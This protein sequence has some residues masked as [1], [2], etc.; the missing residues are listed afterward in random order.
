M[1]D[2][3]EQI[4]VVV[5][6]GK[7]SK[8]A[9][10]PPELKDQD[11]AD[12]IAADALKNGVQPI[13]LLEGCMMGMERIGKEFGEG[14]AFVTNLIVSAE[15]MK[16]VM[17]HIKPFLESGEVQRKGKFVIG[18]VAGDL[19]DIGK[20]LVSMIITGGGFEVI[21]LG[22]DV[23]TNKFLDA[24]AQHPGCFVGLSALLTTTKGNMEK[25]VQAIKKAHPE[26]K[27]LIGGAPIT[28]DF[29]V[30]IGADFYSPNPQDAVA[31]LNKSAS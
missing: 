1:P 18:T 15:A 31:Y 5:S 28:H 8:S 25:S 22:V 26:T 23:P 24:I 14:K 10:Y 16:A 20:N 7:I 19:H 9:W 13:V 21:D 12:E 29:C 4:A 6:K 17:K 2:I 30:H 11:G 3:A 27:V